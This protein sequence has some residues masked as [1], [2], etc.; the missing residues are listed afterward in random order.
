MSGSPLIIPVS[1]SFQI[2]GR[3]APTE[4]LKAG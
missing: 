2:Q 3:L 4:V 1:G